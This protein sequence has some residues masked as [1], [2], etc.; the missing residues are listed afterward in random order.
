ME[1]DLFIRKAG[2]LAALGRAAQAKAVVTKAL[3]RFPDIS[4]EKQISP[5][6]FA[7]HER[8][9]YIETMRKAGFPACA[10]TEELAKFEKPIP[11]PECE[12]ERASTTA[13]RS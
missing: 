3:A 10:K 4:I 7:D 5:P 9:R 8:Q 12:A 13:A 6:G 2:S 1:P 11:L